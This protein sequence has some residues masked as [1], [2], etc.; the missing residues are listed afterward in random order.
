MNTTTSIAASS[1]HQAD[2]QLGAHLV[3]LRR[4]Y[5][6]H[7]IYVGDGQVVH[8]MGLSSALRRGPVA[9]VTLEQ[10][11]SGRVVSIEP[12]PAAAYTPIEIVKRAQSRLGEDRY[13]LL[14]NNCEHLCAWCTHG[15]ARAALRWIA[16]CAGRSAWCKP[17][18]RCC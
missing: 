14:H 9:K 1:L 6:H 11:A 18:V 10:F 4:G 7:G 8:Y 16:C 3:T 13:S 2:I 15:V 12:E 5:T 17:P